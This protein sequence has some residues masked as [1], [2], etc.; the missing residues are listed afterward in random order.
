MPFRERTRVM[1]REEFARLAA[2][3]AN[4]SALCRRFGITRRTG[5]RWLGRY[6]AGGVPGLVDRSRRPHTSPR[7]TPPALE[8]AIITLRG[9]HPTW[10]GRKLAARLRAR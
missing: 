3:D 1:L 10:G 6:E 8:H 7:Q 9:E 4:F 5:Y 2:D